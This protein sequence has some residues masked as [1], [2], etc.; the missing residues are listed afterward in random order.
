MLGFPSP[1]ATPEVVFGPK[2]GR[3]LVEVQSPMVI[4]GNDGTAAEGENEKTV[5]LQ[6][7]QRTTAE[8]ALSFSSRS[9]GFQ[10]GVRFTF[11]GT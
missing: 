8:F 9:R 7:R 1:S 10:F 5:L 11:E 6:I 3:I 2:V 4:T